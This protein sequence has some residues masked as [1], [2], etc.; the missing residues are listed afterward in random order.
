MGE[1]GLLHPD[2]KPAMRKNKPDQN[3]MFFKS[4]KSQ[5]SPKGITINK[6]GLENVITLSQRPS[7][8]RIKNSH[9]G[10]I[11]NTLVSGSAVT[12]VLKCLSPIPL[13][14]ARDP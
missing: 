14:T 1:L 10:L 11:L 12:H 4:S 13:D 2:S 6:C 7:E 3:Q 9:S 5:Q 8:A